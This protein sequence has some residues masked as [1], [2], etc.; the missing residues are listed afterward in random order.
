MQLFALSGS[1]AGTVTQTGSAGHVLHRK[2]VDYSLENIHHV[3]ECGCTPE[4]TYILVTGLSRNT[5]IALSSNNGVRQLR[6]VLVGL[7]DPAVIVLPSPDGLCTNVEGF[8]SFFGAMQSQNLAIAHCNST[9]ITQEFDVVQ[10][11]VV[12]KAMTSA[13]QIALEHIGLA[14]FVNS[15]V[16]AGLNKVM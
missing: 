11:T 9:G 13:Q 14:D 1:P 4:V 16:M 5:D 12:M 2:R 3:T 6:E 8:L 7:K 15:M 10:M